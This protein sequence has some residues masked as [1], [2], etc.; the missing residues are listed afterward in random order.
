MLV[1][2]RVR[3]VVRESRAAKACGAALLSSYGELRRFQRAD[4]RPWD[5]SDLV[6]RPYRV[7]RYQPVLFATDST[8]HLADALHGFLDDVDEDTRDRRRLPP[9]AARGFMGRPADGGA[10]APLS[11]RCR[12][13]IG[14]AKGPAQ[15]RVAVPCR[16]VG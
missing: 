12:A 8:D 15:D 14:S 3:R 1:Q 6:T 11:R 10:R 16:A 2:P 9:L 4:I 7:A 5:I 13:A